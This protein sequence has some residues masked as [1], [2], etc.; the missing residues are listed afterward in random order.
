MN[1]TPSQFDQECFFITPIGE[2]GSLERKRADGVM[3]AVVEPAAAAHGLRVIRADEMA[4][5]GTITT[6]IVEHVVGAKAVVA[7]LTGENANVFY[8][9]AVRDAANLP[10]VMIAEVGTS[11][12]FDK[13]QD[14]TIFFEATDLASV[15]DAKDLLTDFLRASL[16]GKMGNPISSAMVWK[17]YSASGKPVEEAVAQLAEQI[18]QVAA[19]VQRLSK[20]QVLGEGID[21]TPTVKVR[22][23]AEAVRRTYLKELHP[24]GPQEPERFTFI[25]GLDGNSK[26]VDPDPRNPA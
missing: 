3:R 22:V 13:A 2:E 4:E 6:Q 19:D 23:P 21:S 26:P 10:A 15:C 16:E 25:K 8:E 24:D 20:R 11:L 12:P 17:Q 1:V 5:P 18:S 14:R 7:D 9:L